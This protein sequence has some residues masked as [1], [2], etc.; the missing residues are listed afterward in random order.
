LN[1]GKE[2]NFNKYSHGQIDTLK[3]PY[4]FQSLM[5]YGKHS[6]SKNGEP[7]LLSI[8]NPS[9]TLGQRNGFTKTDAL[10]INALYDCSGIY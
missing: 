4:D 1:L 6:F 10:E 8:S 5:H 7:T 2:H 3:A 9:Q